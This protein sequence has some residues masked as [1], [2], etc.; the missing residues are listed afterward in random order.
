MREVPQLA[1]VVNPPAESPMFTTIQYLS[2]NR[3]VI[4][5][6]TGSTLHLIKNEARRPVYWHIHS[7]FLETNNSK[8]VNVLFP[9]EDTRVCTLEDIFTSK[10]IIGFNVI[11]LFYIPYSNIGNI[12]HW[13]HRIFSNLSDGSIQRSH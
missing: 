1:H 11:N 13:I 12:M 2:I 6:T 7:M 10:S 3:L 9:H 5:D 8:L 4:D